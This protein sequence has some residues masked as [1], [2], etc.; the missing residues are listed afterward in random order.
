MMDKPN[1]GLK[2]RRTYQAPG[3]ALVVTTIFSLFLLAGVIHALSNL[4][5]TGGLIFGATT[6]LVVSPFVYRSWRSG[7]ISI[8]DQGVVIRSLL[9]TRRL[10]WSDIRAFRAQTMRVGAGG[11]QRHVLVVV[12]GRGIEHAYKEFNSAPSKDDQQSLVERVAGVLNARLAGV[13]S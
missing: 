13:R 5:S 3:Q 4:R 8:G 9:S 6:V 11:Y 1:T 7:S 12:D 10:Q 2:A